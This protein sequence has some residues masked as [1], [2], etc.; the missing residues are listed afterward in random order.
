[1]REPVL[2]TPLFTSATRLAGLGS[3]TLRPVGKGDHF[4]HYA[5][6][7]TANPGN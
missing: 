4:P 3:P 1:M 5:G 6:K 7:R 2:R